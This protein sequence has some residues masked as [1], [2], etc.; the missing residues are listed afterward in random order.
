[1][2][3]A[4]SPVTPAT[5]AARTEPA[6]PASEGKADGE[7][8]VTVFGFSLRDTN[9]V[10]REFEKCG[11]ILRHHSG[12][13]EGNWIHIL[14]QALLRCKESPSKEWYPAMQWRHNWSKA[15]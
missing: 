3:E 7:E 1:A 10:L 15:Y 13:R 12:P 5:E 4:P 11:V 6:A 2:G 9:L 8:W 14:Y